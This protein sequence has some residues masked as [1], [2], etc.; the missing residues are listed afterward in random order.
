MHLSQEVAIKGDMPRPSLL[1]APLI[2]RIPYDKR[3]SGSQ[4]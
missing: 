3:C 2:S 4:F 1:K